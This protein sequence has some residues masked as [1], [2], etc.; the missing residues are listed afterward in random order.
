M[1]PI[2]LL[3]YAGYTTMKSFHRT[4]PGDGEVVL[5]FPNMETGISFSKLLLPLIT[6]TDDNAMRDATKYLRR[7]LLANNLDGLKDCINHLLAQLPYE[8]H[9][10]QSKTEKDDLLLREHYYQTIFYLWLTAAGFFTTPEDM[11]NR[12][13]IDLTVVIN[14]M[15]YIFEL[16][17]DQSATAAIQQIKDRDY[18]TKYRTAG[19]HIYA[20]GVALNV[21]DRCVDELAYELL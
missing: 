14:K 13:R 20:V 12:G 5:G 11:T 16:K 21:K 19:R 3:Y 18:A 15:V 10:K 7:L 4:T 2:M 17:M 8:L 1:D 9:G 6:K